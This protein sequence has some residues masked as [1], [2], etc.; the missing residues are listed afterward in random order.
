MNR[1]TWD[2]LVVHNPMLIEIQ[3][4][5]RRY[6][7]FGGSNSMNSAVLGLALVCYAGLVLIVL[8]ADG[9]LSPLWLVILQSGLFTVF[10]PG[11]LHGA[12]AG[13][14]ER[15]SW[16]L[17]LVAPITKAQIVVGK[18]IGALAAL[19]TAVGLFLFPVLL[20]AAKH[21]STN[22]I[23]LV[24]ME[25]LSFSFGVAVCAL[26]LLISARVRRPFMALG[27]SLG[28]LGVTLLVLP[29]LV[30]VMVSGAGGQSME[31]LYYLHPFAV[32]GQVATI[33]ERSY[34]RESAV[35]PDHFWGWPQV[36]IYLALAAV[37]VAWAAN[38]L[39]FAENEVKFIPQGHRGA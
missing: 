35:I 8:N 21:S 4:F 25:A 17:L 39:N 38:T 30:G 6:F 12:I 14:R 31:A 26:T 37:M 7:S 29:M 23:D 33:S 1:K 36:I 28:T 11:M 3:R 24:L 2:E 34:P 19:G 15:R 10:A 32:M 20:A 13:E 18:F 22:W 27:V 16:D 9:G 5:R